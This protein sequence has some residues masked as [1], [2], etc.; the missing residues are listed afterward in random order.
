VIY[1]A[2]LLGLAAGASVW[3]GRAMWRSRGQRERK[4]GITGVVAWIAGE[5]LL[6]AGVGAFVAVGLAQADN[7][8]IGAI[9]AGAVVLLGLTAVEAAVR[10]VT[11]ARHLIRFGTLLVVAT[12]ALMLVTYLADRADFDRTGIGPVLQSLVFGAL[13]A[14]VAA[15]FLRLAGDPA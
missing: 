14:F 13:P 1:T 2:S 9:W 11:A 5:G 6:L 7:V 4:V 15:A 10:P 12:A 3:L 8:D